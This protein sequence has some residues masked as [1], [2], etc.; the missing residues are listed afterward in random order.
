VASFLRH[1]IDLRKNELPWLLFAA[2]DKTLGMPCIYNAAEEMADLLAFML[3][4]ICEMAF[5]GDH[6]PATTYQLQQISQHRSMSPL[7]TPSLKKINPTK[8]LTQRTQIFDDSQV[9]S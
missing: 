9:R 4:T 5:C 3:C 8:K 6:S 2:W 7:I 1:K